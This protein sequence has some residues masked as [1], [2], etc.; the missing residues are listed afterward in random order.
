MAVSPILLNS[1]PFDA[2]LNH[3]LQFTYNGSQ[4]FANRV[5]VKNNTTNA[6]VYDQKNDA[7]T[8]YVTIPANT[9]QNGVTYNVQVSVFDHENIESPLSN[10][11]I[12]QCLATPIFTFS[13]VTNGLTIRSSYIDAELHY[14]Q[15]NGELLNEYIVTLYASNQTTVVYNS[16]YKYSGDSMITRVTGLVDDNTF[17][18]RATGETVHGMEIDTGFI[19][20]LCDYLKPDMFLAFRADNIAEEGSVRLSAHYVLVEGDSNIDESELVYIDDE[21]IS[22]LNGET[23]YWDSGFSAKNFTWDMRLSNIPDF[24]KMITF[25][26]KSV[27]AII[28]WNYGTFDDSGEV[29]YYAELTT[30]HYVGSEQLKYRQVS[31]R[32]SPLIGDQQVHIYVRHVNGL[33]DLVITPLEIPENNDVNIPEPSNPEELIEEIVE[34]SDVE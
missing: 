6:I 26:M 4:I 28:T 5:I 14:S 2:T 33:F 24:T 30:F 3:I 15:E 19:E 32:I 34:G 29:K 12:V 31:N 8:T 18:L 11:I 17:Y 27:K 7:M 16:G 10:I 13:N 23:V 25:N 9:L 21:K 20:V 1:V 22:L